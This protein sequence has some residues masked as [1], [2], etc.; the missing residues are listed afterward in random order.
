MTTRVMPRPTRTTTAAGHSQ[1]RPVPGRPAARAARATFFEEEARPIGG[2]GYGLQGGVRSTPG[3]PVDPRQHD[4]D[5]EGRGDQWQ[6][7]PPPAGAGADGVAP[8]R[9]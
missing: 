7:G 2:P 4:A 5:E 6:Q 8:D 9:A 1:L 3:G